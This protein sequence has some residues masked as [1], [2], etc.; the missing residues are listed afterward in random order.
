MKF[1]CVANIQEQV[2][3][4][5]PQECEFSSVTC[6]NYCGLFCFGRVLFLLFCFVFPD[7]IGSIGDENKLNSK[8]VISLFNNV[9]KICLLMVILV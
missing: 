3:Y 8:S 4:S 9:L 2:K 6:N 7:V 1:P 5:L